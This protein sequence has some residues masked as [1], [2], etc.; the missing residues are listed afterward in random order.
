M[1]DVF[2]N[3]SIWA[4]KVKPTQSR[5]AADVETAKRELGKAGEQAD[6]EANKLA[7]SKAV[8]V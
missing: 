4:F 2:N 3:E 5:F 8:E 7:A 6:V 1:D